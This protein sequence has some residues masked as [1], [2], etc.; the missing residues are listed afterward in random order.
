MHLDVRVRLLERPHAL[1]R[2]VRVLVAEVRH[3]RHGG[4]AR[5]LA[6]H[7]HAAAVIRHRGRQPRHLLGS[8]PRQQPAPA[9]ADDAHLARARREVHRSLDVLQHPRERQRLDG[10][11]Q[12][13]PALHVVRRVAELHAGLH[14]VERGR[15]DR[16]VAGGRVAIGDGA[17][18]RVDAEDL[19]QHDDGALGRMRRL[20]DVGGG[21]EAV[22]GGERD[23]GGRHGHS[24]QW[25]DG[26]PL[27]RGFR[28]LHPIRT[29]CRP[30]GPAAP[31]GGSRL[32][33]G[34]ALACISR[35]RSHVGQTLYP[36]A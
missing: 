30:A 12:A 23:R 32:P 3:R 14:P 27:R 34:A 15:R 36:I 20:A 28:L 18:V 21:L 1:E 11:L 6:A 8:A 31:T 25:S 29:H 4:L 5:R 26:A 10:G 9:I 22:G 19:L 7:R 16:E 33:L 17:D 2:D 13:R 24:L 35:P